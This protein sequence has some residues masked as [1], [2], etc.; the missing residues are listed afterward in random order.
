MPTSNSEL[1][2]AIGQMDQ[3]RE[4]YGPNLILV[5]LA[6]FIS[7]AQKQLFVSAATTRG[8]EIIE[9]IER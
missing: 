9:I 7:E 4:R 5:L 6:D 1:Q 8:I 2:R 3:Y